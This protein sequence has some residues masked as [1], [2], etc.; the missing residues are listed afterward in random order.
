MDITDAQWTCEG[1]LVP[2]SLEMVSVPELVVYRFG[3][4]VAQ[5]VKRSINAPEIGILLASSLPA[6]NY[7]HNAFRNSFFY[8]HSQKILFI[9]R[10][11]LASVGTFSVL[12]VHCL[13][14]LATDELSDD[15]NPLFLQ[16]FHQ[17]L[18]TLFEDMFFIRFQILPPMNAHK[19]RAPTSNKLFQKEFDL[20]IYTDAISDLLNFDM[21]DSQ[22]LTMFAEQLQQRT[23]AWNSKTTG[24]PSKDQQADIIKECL[25][26][27]SEIQ[28]DN[29][30]FFKSKSELDLEEIE[31]KIDNITMELSAIFDAEQKVQ[32]SMV[33]I[34]KKRAFLK[35]IEELETELDSKKK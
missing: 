25:Q 12:L 13:S 3:I 8:Q 7:T 6:N 10:Q 23:E 33:S 19:P 9:R 1:R 34:S 5:L 20:E 15:S 17:A 32:W 24:T 21:K 4:F 16:L 35:E 29:G 31:E 2:V 30:I 27:E 26:S 18:K 28:K 11:Q 22:A 14:H